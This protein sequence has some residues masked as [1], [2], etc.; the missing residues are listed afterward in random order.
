M[1]MFLPFELFSVLAE[2]AL[3]RLIGTVAL[4]VGVA[5]LVTWNGRPQPAPTTGGG[6]GLVAARPGAV[7]VAHLSALLTGFCFV[8]AGLYLWTR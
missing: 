6:G 3:A 2:A 4:A 7:S 8:L 5:V 1:F